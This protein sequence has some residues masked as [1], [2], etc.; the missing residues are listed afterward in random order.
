MSRIL[1]VRVGKFPGI[2]GL[3]PLKHGAAAGGASA[4]WGPIDFPDLQR[5]LIFPSET[6]KS[7]NEVGLPRIETASVVFVIQGCT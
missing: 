1:L 3:A 6:S 4:K 5:N 7:K 2:L